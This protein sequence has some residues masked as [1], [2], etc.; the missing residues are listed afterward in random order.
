MDFL[1]AIKASVYQK[2]CN[3]ATPCRKCVCAVP[4]T[5]V[6]KSMDPN[7]SEGFEA[8]VYFPALT[9]RKIIIKVKTR[10]IKYLQLNFGY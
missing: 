1:K 6:E 2:E 7:C 5:E 3:A 8:Y 4:E 10:N 9:K